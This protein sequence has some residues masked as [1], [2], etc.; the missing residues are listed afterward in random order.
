[1]ETESSQVIAEVKLNNIRGV[2]AKANRLEDKALLLE[3]E[4]SLESIYAMLSMG[5]PLANIANSFDLSLDDAKFIL[6]RTT[7]HRK[8]Y[9][10]AIQFRR[11]IQSDRTM[12]KFKSEESLDKE[13]NN[14]AKYHLSVMDAAS[15]AL[16]ATKGEKGANITVE[17][18]IIV[19]SKD[20]VPD[21]PDE[22]KN[23]M[24]GEFTDVD[25]KT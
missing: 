10:A 11:A 2:L 16:N 9:I 4:V 22:L 1:M 13:Q 17:N 15:K 3:R 14:A 20:D 24:E 21:L 19:R 25:T 8:Q 23:I 7:E 18:K 6:T 12:S 5:E